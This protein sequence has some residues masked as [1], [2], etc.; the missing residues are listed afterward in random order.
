MILNRLQGEKEAVQISE[1]TYLIGAKSF[2]IEGVLL[3]QKIRGGR[4]SLSTYL[5]TIGHHPSLFLMGVGHI[6]RVLVI[7]EQDLHILIIFSTV[8]TTWDQ[9]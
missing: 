7:H 3:L 5:G 6:C 4:T 8:P 9:K 2:G 1:Q